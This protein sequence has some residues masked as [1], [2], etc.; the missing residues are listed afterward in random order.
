MN[1]RITEE[2]WNE[3]QQAER[4][5]HDNFLNKA[6]VEGVR[7]HYERTY[8]KYFKYLGI[9]KNQ[10]NKTIIEIGCADF[11]ALEHCENVKGILIEPLPSELLTS[12]VMFR[13]DLYL[14]QAKVEETNL[15]EADEVWLLNVMQ[16]VL[17]PD[18]FIQKCK[19][20][21]KVI[22]FF[23]PIDWPIEIYHPHTFDL[24]WYKSHFGE[25]VNLYTGEDR[26]FHS[27]NCAYGVW[28]GK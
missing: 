12:L 8:G 16:H 24:D 11:P 25:S 7:S 22:R 26:E 10:Q 9:E 14:I 27:A 23:E 13:P 28:K 19:E 15:P 21:A 5:C 18:L 20:S 2:R 6:G 3:A 17:D 1:K 4:V